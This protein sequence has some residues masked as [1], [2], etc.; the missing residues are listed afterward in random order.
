[1]ERLY[2]NRPLDR[3]FWRI[4]FVFV[5]KGRCS[6][7]TRAVPYYPL[8]RVINATGVVL[9]TGL[10]RA[11]YGEA[12]L[13]RAYELLAGYSNLEFR[14]NDGTR[15]KRDELIVEPLKRITG[16]EDAL[17]CNNNAAAVV[18]ALRTFAAGGAA[19]VS[20]QQLIEIGGSFRLPEVM[21]AGGVDLMPVGHVNRC[22]A[23]DY[24][25]TL[26]AGAAMVLMAHRSNFSFRGEFVEPDVGEVSAVAR[27]RGRPVIF[28]LGSGLLDPVLYP[29][30]DLSAEPSVRALLAAGVDVVT[31]SG[32]KLL[33][34]PQAGVVCGR[35]EWVSKMRADQFLRAFRAGKETY[36][37]LTAVLERYDEGGDAMADI[38][39]WRML[40]AAAEELKTKAERLAGL[41]GEGLPD[42]EVSVEAGES[43]PGGGTLPDLLLPTRLVK[44]SVEGFTPNRLATVFRECNP[45]VVG[46]AEGDGFYLDVRTVFYNDMADF[47]AI[48]E[49]VGSKLA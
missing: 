38:P 36:A 7:Y 3:C 44:V 49:Q 4:L 9:H 18:L 1:M 34:G 47:G 23:A 12:L 43:L 10:G 40:N 35:A 30:L 19:A 5:D 37:L 26:E 27:R 42:A 22:T 33:G 48:S 17:V 8:Q 31:F 14:L 11:P 16:A 45:P 32:D 24:E 28:D 20:R 2:G 41:L 13:K 29:N 39:A 46:R 21:R 15:G 6:T 25:P